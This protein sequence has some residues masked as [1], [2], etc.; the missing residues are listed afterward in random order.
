MNLEKKETIATWFK[1]EVTD[2]SKTSKLINEKTQRIG[3]F[4]AS[5][6]LFSNLNKWFEDQSEKDVTEHAGTQLIA[7]FSA[8][9]AALQR[10]ENNIAKEGLKKLFEK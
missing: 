1:V 8:L 10:K 2:Q 3:L 6:S 9:V 4:L 5:V 7:D